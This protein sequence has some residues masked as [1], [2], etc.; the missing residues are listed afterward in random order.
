ESTSTP[1][2]VTT[3]FPSESRVLA[4]KSDSQ[5]VQASADEKLLEQMLAKRNPQDPS[6]PSGDEPVPTDVSP[7]S[8]PR[9]LEDGLGADSIDA[10]V[11]PPVPSGEPLLQDEGLR[12]RPARNGGPERNL[13]DEDAVLG[14]RLREVE[15]V[16]VESMPPPDSTEA[17]PVVETAPQPAVQETA[18]PAPP[19]KPDWI[20]PEYYVNVIIP[21][22]LTLHSLLTSIETNFQGT[23]Y[24]DRASVLKRGLIAY[25]DESFAP[26][27]TTQV[28]KPEALGATS[29]GGVSDTT[30]VSL[31]R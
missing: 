6:V 30:L 18:G 15:N 21:Q 23:E 11:E 24:G 3:V 25:R 9:V 14:R 4:P 29:A 12:L 7:V 5:A 27:T 20:K 8:G 28:A 22:P 19:K 1:D 26:S 2:S 10:E 31:D 13:D 16:E 17:N